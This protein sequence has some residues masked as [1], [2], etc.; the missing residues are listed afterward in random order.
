MIEEQ[1]VSYASR[2]SAA[3]INILTSATTQYIYDGM[4]QVV[5]RRYY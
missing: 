3:F 1:V 4:G 2:V 5:D